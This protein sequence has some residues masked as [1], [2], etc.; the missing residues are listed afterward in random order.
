[1][2]LGLQRKKKSMRPS[3]D[4]DQ[5]MPTRRSH[6]SVHQ[7]EGRR[8]IHSQ[9]EEAPA[10][11][12]LRREKP[13]AQQLQDVANEFGTCSS[14][15]PRPKHF[16]YLSPWEPTVKYNLL[17]RPTDHDRQRMPPDTHSDMPSS[18]ITYSS[19]RSPSSTSGTTTPAPSH[20][21][22]PPN[23]NLPPIPLPVVDSEASTMSCEQRV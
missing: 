15:P 4:T 2:I 23:S 16:R 14:L 9:A 18:A 11:G 5:L 22:T 21:P 3:T 8:S 7:A 20:L 17:T 1:M 6:L 13:T 19:A 10:E 12:G